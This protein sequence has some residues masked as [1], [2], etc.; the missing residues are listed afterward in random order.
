MALA[1]GVLAPKFAM[2]LVVIGSFLGLWWAI[3]EL[4]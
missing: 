1:V 2:A 3:R 4:S